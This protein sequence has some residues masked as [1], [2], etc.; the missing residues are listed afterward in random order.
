MFALQAVTRKDKKARN[1]RQ[2]EAANIEGLGIAD[3][4]DLGDF[5]ELAALVRKTSSRSM[6]DPN[7]RVVSAGSSVAP[8]ESGVAALQRA[9]NAFAVSSEVQ[10]KKASIRTDDVETVRE[11]LKKR[12]SGS[13]SGTAFSAEAEEEAAQVNGSLGEEDRM[14]Q[15]TSRV[16]RKA[17]GTY[18]EDGDEDMRIEDG[19]EG[20]EG[21]MDVVEILAEQKRKFAEHKKQHYK[22]APKFAGLDGE[23]TLPMSNK[24][25]ASLEIVMNRGLVPHRKK[26]NKNPRVKKRNAFEK[27]KIARRGQVREAVSGVAGAYAGEKTGIKT[28]LARSRKFSS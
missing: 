4:G 13:G 28:N 1:K 22:P 5:D 18:L 9:V 14:G 23:E 11:A 15:G 7:E 2:R 25:A 16:R 19:D 20:D 3:V 8:A 24:R 26:A 6:A 27:A 21:D 10:R 17:P 12:G